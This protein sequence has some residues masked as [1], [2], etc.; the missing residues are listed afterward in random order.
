VHH[1]VCEYVFNTVLDLQLDKQDR[2][3]VRM[4]VCVRVCIYECMYG[5]FPSQPSFMKLPYIN[6]NIRHHTV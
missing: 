2:V 1:D 4:Y 5:C 6:N 3:W